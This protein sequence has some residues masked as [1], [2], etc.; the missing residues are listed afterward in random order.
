MK[1]SSALPV[2]ALASAA[3]AL[4]NSGFSLDPLLRNPKDIIASRQAHLR[5][6]LVDICAGLDVDLELLDIIGPDGKSF[7][8][9]VSHYFYSCIGRVQVNP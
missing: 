1:F 5:R 7:H 3:S 8:I 4:S 9:H 6:G 2:L